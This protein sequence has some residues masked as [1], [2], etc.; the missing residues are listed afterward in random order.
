M[1][2]SSGILLALSWPSDGFAPL[3]FIGL[4]PL[5]W[6]EAVL[7][8]SAKKHRQ[9]LIFPFA[10]IAFTLWN[11]SVI[12]WLHYSQRPD[13]S[14]AWEAYFPPVLFNALLM[15]GL[16]RVCTWVKNR[17]G[18]SSGQVFLVCLWISFEK[19][20]LQWELAWPW[21]NMGNGMAHYFKWIQWY[22]YTGTLGG[23][24]WIWIVNFGIFNAARNY[25]FNRNKAILYKKLFFN[26]I[27][28]LLPIGF[29]YLLYAR[30]QER[31]REVEVIVLQPNID[32]YKEKYQKSENIIV[33]DLIQLSQ[34]QLTKNTRFLLAPETAF[35][36]L[37]HLNYLE[38]NLAIK[39]LCEFVRAIPQLAFVLGVEIYTEYNSKEIASES[40]SFSKESG[41]WTDVFNSALQ[42]DA[43]KSFTLYHKSKLVP[44]VE[45]FPYKKFLQP[46]LGDLLLDF[47]GTIMS[48]G[49]QMEPS[50]FTHPT[51]KVTLAP[52][53]CYESVFGEHVGE[54]ILKG[55]QLIFILT[56]D[57]WW[58]NSKGHKQH[59]A[60]ARLR[61]IENRRSV[62]RSANTG[63][64]AFIDQK[65]ELLS[66]LPYGK[67]GVLRTHL[68][69]NDKQTFY[70]LYGD[71]VAR[72]A[73]LLGGVL[74]AYALSYDLLKQRWFLF[75]TISNI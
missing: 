43:S 35:S 12:W 41:R 70:S 48:H 1:A 30:Y 67:K 58:G 32:P 42:I 39:A 10:F 9:H 53:I 23:T 50:V 33:N 18:V 17:L 31:G 38:K 27:K 63:I 55:A 16:L 61:A 60:Y 44:G 45:S 64:S 57:G 21:M 46:I 19:L 15:A 52:V 4:V 36:H 73:L 2:V 75:I 65:G 6:M 66:T 62:A 47:G 49:R 7:S 14:Y 3:M 28:I 13:G 69:A 11:A 68:F 25:Y 72:F 34:S 40:A 56:N 24:L 26:G 71:F 37:A 20:Q 74:F 8:N 54:Y 5:L 59:L 29:S 51:E 22:E